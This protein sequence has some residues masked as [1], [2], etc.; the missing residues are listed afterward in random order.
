MRPIILQA[1][2]T[3]DCNL[4]CKICMRRYL[5]R[6]IGYM[7]FENFKKLPLNKFKEVAFHG[8]GEPLLHPQLFDMI[9]FAKSMGIKTSLITNATLLD[10]DRVEKLINSGL[11]EIAFGIYR[12]EALSKR[13]RNIQRFI[14][15][16][17]ESKTKIKTYFDITIYS[18]NLD[19]I[20]EIIEVAASL[21]VD[22][23]VLHRLFN[24]YKVDKTAEYISEKEEKEL[25]RK[26]KK[27]G[28]K[29][30]VK[31]FLPKKH[32]IPCRI[33]KYCTFVTWDCKLTPCCF[34]SEE[35][36]GDA[37]EN[38]FEKHERFVRKM[39]EHEICRRCI[40]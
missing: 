7:S 6:E 33:V 14:E 21:G 13:F 29:A 24:I 1:E 15:A 17:K 25:F 3:N 34:L 20:P 11:D 10:K 22:A 32:K 31:V 8:W 5:D 40:W 2:L 16:K 38:V 37:F 4:S 12:K 19:E 18:E 23:I 28:K 36:L 27:A 26:A 30:G 9:R 35:Y 39:R